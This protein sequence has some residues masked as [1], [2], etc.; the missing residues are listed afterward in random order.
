[1]TPPR[2]FGPGELRP[3][4]ARL[5]RLPSRRPQD[6]AGEV[7]EE[8][9]LHLQL[10]A[11]QLAAEGMGPEAARAEAELRFGPLDEARER[12]HTSARRREDI[13]QLR[14][15]LDALRRDLLY[16]WRGVRRAPAFAAIV[17]ATL[18]LGI[19]AA[20]AVFSVVYGVLLRPLPYPD[21][22]RVM[23]VYT[24]MP[25]VGVE[26]GNVSEPEFLDLATAPAARGVFER[27]AL[28]QLRASTVTGVG[29][30][31]R[32]PAIYA[33]AS[34]FRTLRTPALLGRT[35]TADEDRP[36]AGAVVVLAHGYWQRRFGGDPAAVGRVLRV[37][38]APRTVV[39]VMPAA[40][41][42]G[43][44]DLYA[45]RALD[46]GMPDNRQAHNDQAVA[47]LAPGATPAQ[48]RAAL[49]VLATRLR[50][51]HPAAYAPGLGFDFTAVPLQEATVGAARPAL[52]VLAAAV[53]LVLL[54][55]CANAANLLLARGAVRRRELALR[56]ALGAGRARVV[57]QLLTESAV[58]AVIAGAAGLVGASV[59][60]RALLAVNPDALPRQ[61]AVGLDGVVVAAALGLSVLTGLLFGTLPALYA[62]RADLH[63]VFRAGGRGASAAASTGLRRALVIGEVALAVV[64]VTAAGLLGRSFHALRTVDAGLEPAG[65][66]TLAMSLPD[67]R[68]QN[69]RVEPTY[70]AL[71]ERVR[72]LPGVAAA[73]GVMTLPLGGG[74]GAWDVDVEGRPVAP[75]APKPGLRPQILTP[76]ALAALGMP[77]VRGRDLR[78]GDDA[79]GPL[80]ALVNESAARVLWPGTDGL[81]R[82]FRVTGNADTT[83]LTVVGVVRDA[84]SAG[85]DQ[86][87]PPE[88]Y[89]PHAQNARR[90]R[91]YPW[92]D[93]TLVV[94]TAGDPAQLVAPVR[95]EVGRLDPELAVTD[96]RTMRQVIDRSVAQPR[97]TTLVLA[98]FGAAALALAALGV[99]GVIAYGVAQRAREF[100]IRAALGARRADVLRV[101]VGQGLGLAAAGTGV[102]LLGALAATRLLRALLFGV[103][104]T[105]P[106]TFAVIPLVLLGVAALASLVP[107]RRALRADA[108][109]ALRAD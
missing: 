50:R 35:F 105:D 93:L 84:R 22:D 74:G 67:S 2:P 108:T 103:S 83:W 21:A 64:V 102:G 82:R 78:D 55:A 59:G 73:G 48:A 23:A 15:A 56:A 4:V 18:A 42:F 97:L 17:V 76:G 13:V 58:L 86:T 38:G 10:R 27:V 30:P 14:E 92:R 45:P 109:A 33:T 106:V 98:A 11:A 5:F 99:Y 28:S 54:I 87:P 65:V 89:L 12:L 29:T 70:A 100:A 39:G 66:L 44:A 62:S 7:D 19:G 52:E 25:G 36:G 6:V 81:G 61:H 71:L 16:A 31:E 75:G 20:T 63:G 41:D 96:V 47:R 104:P 85:L 53:G 77:V 68:Y 34:L 46:A 51:D 79:R 49:A 91:G 24:R 72:A 101:V 43:G 26:Q 3:G 40:F 69:G 90:T 107:A 8:I 80:V 95:R 94:R 1:M 9:R 32:V 88:M 57:R 60:V 37:D